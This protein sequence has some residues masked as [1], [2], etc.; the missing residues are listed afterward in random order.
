MTDV[1]ANPGADRRVDLDW[2]RI[3]A[4]GILILYHIGMFYV[5]WGWHV[6]SSRASDAIEPLMRLVNPWRLDLLMFISGV[7]TRFMSDKVSAGAMAVTRFHRLF[8]PLVFGVFIIVPP[9]A[10]YEIAETVTRFGP[11]ASPGFTGDPWTFYRSYI[12][13]Q[14]A[15]SAE[16]GRLIMP[17]W[18]HLWFVAYLLVY[19]MLIC[20]VMP[21]VRRIPASIV[22]ATT[23]L[24]A[25]FFFL[26][27]TRAVLFPLFGDTHALV[28]D[29]YNHVTF[30]GLFLLG[31]VIARTDAP[32]EAAMRWRWWALGISLV[33]WPGALV[34]DAH[35]DIPMLHQGAIWGRGFRS[36][37]TWAAI[38]ALLG[39]AWRHWRTDNPTRRYLT[40]AIFPFY[41]FHQT[42]IVVA[43]HHLDR[44][45]WPVALEA[46]T[47][48]AITAAACF[49]GYEIVRRVSFLRPFFGLRPLAKA[50]AG[51]RTLRHDA[52]GPI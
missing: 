37:Q 10:Y 31:F 29:W 6:K 4:F 16:G 14:Y 46:A 41:I 18:N 19:T 48:I 17:T 34:F 36:V 51:G 43:A 3:V 27:A 7:A 11:T 38:I 50:T 8:W 47:L 30:G 5:S 44:L 20:L 45:K 1:P 42:V 39:F 52:R 15:M 28:D 9:Q 26:W 23:F 22:S 12:T 35:S 13:A 40:D 24:I 2:L 21:L 49:T 32:F 33:A 25:P